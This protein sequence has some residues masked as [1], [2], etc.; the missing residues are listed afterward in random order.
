MNAEGTEPDIEIR[1]MRQH[2]LRP[3]AVTVARAFRDNPMTVACWGSDAVRR[4]RGL[5][6][7]FL[8]LLPTVTP[9][10]SVAVRDGAVV[11]ALGYA[12]MGRCRQMQFLPSVRALAALAVRNPAA[13]IR[14]GRWMAEYE[15]R[16]PG[17][18]HYHL[19]PVAVTPE[20][21]C[22]GI[23]SSLLARFCSA[24][25][26]AGAAAYLETDQAVNMRRY[27][28]VGFVTIDQAPI[29]GVTNWFMWRA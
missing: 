26:A 13:A 15:R 3:A 21:Q 19:G 12:A 4:E 28:R 11:G 23:G 20:L 22:T 27:E 25:D 8:Q 6:S 18:A 1:P 2:E 10:L 14:F 7:L 5:M 16:D 29:L 17:D 24:V 9:V